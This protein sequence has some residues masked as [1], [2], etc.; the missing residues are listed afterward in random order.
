M[1][2][3]MRGVRVKVVAI[4]GSPHKGNSLRR[5]NV[6]EGKL[7]ELGDVEFEYLHLKDMDVQPCRGCFKCFMRGE[8][9]CPIDDDVASIVEKMDA[10]DGVIFASPVYAMHISYL[11]KTLIDRMGYVFHRPRFFGKY[12]LAVAV[13]GSPGLDE[14]LKYIEG[15]EM[16]MGFHVVD[17]LGYIDP[18]KGTPLRAIM[19]RRDRTDEVV[20]RFY[21]AMRTNQARRLRFRDYL[22][23]H[24]T[25]AVYQRM[26]PMNPRDYAYWK[27]RGWLE[28]DARF[29]YDNVRGNPLSNAMGRFIGWMMGRQV[30][31]AL[32]GST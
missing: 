13:A 32:A 23:F 8:G 17:K 16:I 31:K 30:D 6:I 4:M 25:K 9:S 2:G 14:T 3:P 10:A 19:Q 7:R 11:L 20:A 27:E 24:T 28:K 15:A 5:V 21:Q 29:F 26:E 12:A 18:P 1:W 22:W